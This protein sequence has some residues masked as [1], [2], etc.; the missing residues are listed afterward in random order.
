MNMIKKISALLLAVLLMA[1]FSITAFAEDN[2]DDGKEID[3]DIEENHGDN[4]TVTDYGTIWKNY[5]TVSE[6][7]GNVNVNAGTVSENNGKVDANAG[8]VVNNNDGGAVNGNFRTIGAYTDDGK[9]DTTHGNFGTVSGNYPGANAGLTTNGNILYNGPTGVIGD[10][11][12]YSHW[13]LGNFSTVDINDGR[14]VT[15][16]SGGEVKTNNEIITTNKGTVTENKSIG[17]IETNAKDGVVTTNTGKV[18][19][20]QAGGTVTTNNGTVG[21]VDTFGNPVSGTGNYGKV[22]DNSGTVYNQGGTVVNNNG[23]VKNFSGEVTNNEADGKV[24]NGSAGTVVNNKGEVNHYSANNGVVNNSGT[25]RINGNNSTA[26]V[27]NNFNDKD[28]YNGQIIDDMGITGPSD[29]TYL[30]QHQFH[31]YA[32]ITTEGCDVESF[33]ASADDSV[34][35]FDGKFWLENT[36]DPSGTVSVTLSESYNGI[37]TSVDGVETSNTSTDDYVFNVSGSGS[38][39]TLTFKKLIRNIKITL[40]G[41]NDPQPDPTLDPPKPEPKPQPSSPMFVTTYKLKFDLGGGVMP[42]GKTELELKCSAGQHIKLP[43]APTREGFTFAGWETTIRGKTV[44][45]EA[46]AK[47]TVTAGKTFTAIWVEA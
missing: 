17:T 22:D 19:I 16:G 4:V 41:S 45:F 42:D 14:I 13:E 3:S 33:D 34:V 37:K 46:G 15:N 35:E 29:K 11:E 24:N 38:S 39:W 2:Y 12:G 23:E 40:T 20:N 6:N 25:V 43:E 10:G 18:E 47:F 8:T 31:N 26:N 9:V 44:V 28:K 1:S 7:N 27:V 36:T 30:A 32:E 5:G 21:K